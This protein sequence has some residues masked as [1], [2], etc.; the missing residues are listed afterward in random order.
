MDSGQTLLA[1]GDRIRS[2]PS[3]NLA[4][5]T[6]TSLLPCPVP[7]DAITQHCDRNFARDPPTTTRLI[8]LQEVY[9]FFNQ[10]LAKSNMKSDFSTI[11]PS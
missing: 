1:G 8:N 5:T 2:A 9:Y 4:L 11:L 3:M 6:G 10:T 7:I